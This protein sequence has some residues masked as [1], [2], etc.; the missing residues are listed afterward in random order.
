MA[1]EVLFLYRS[2]SLYV[3][4]L[5]VVAENPY[6]GGQV[7]GENSGRSDRRWLVLAVLCMT[8][9]LDALDLS[10]T[11][12]A[13]PSIGTDLGVSATALP[14]VANA[15]VLM[16]GGL[17]LLGGRLSDLLGRRRVFL[18]GLGLF[19]IMSLVCGLAG[20]PALLIGARA[21][22]G[23]GAALT[24]P[25]AVAILAGTFSQGPERNR[26]LGVFAAF[27]GTGFSVGLVAGGALTGALGW[28]WI[29]LVKVPVVA[30]VIALSLI[31][32]KPTPPSDR[33]R[34]FDVVGAVTSTAGL[35]LLALAITLLAAG[36][37]SL[38][39]AVLTAAVAAALLTG[40]WWVE[41]HARDPLLPLQLL[42]NRTVRVAD[43]VSLTVLAAPFGFAYL[44]STYL[45]DVA[46][47]SP[48][49]TGLAVLPG[50]VLSAIISSR[51]APLLV[52]RY[53]LRSCGSASLAVVAAGFA[54]LALVGEQP[55]Y[56]TAVLPACVICFGLGMGVAYP[57][58]TIAALTDVE[59]DEQGLAAGVQNAALQIGGG[60]GLAVVS[61]AVNVFAGSS[62]PT[63]HALVDAVQVGA[64]VG[65]ALPLIGSAASLA[66]LPSSRPTQPTT[67]DA[68]TSTRSA[69]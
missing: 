35:L 60:L 37:R 1:S 30:A 24:V 25:A 63:P 4:F 32:V 31:V 23:V 13:L 5:P 59:E 10:I 57:V 45:Q 29:F 11:Q 3:H 33:G 38:L 39:P 7:D 56:L 41:R 62:N 34:S 21:A 28:P 52:K 58:F 67:T 22:Q 2:V 69:P 46:G 53:G 44:A 50:S 6:G 61:S 36:S 48:L 14:W 49:R 55:S 54:M 12:V 9:L 65:A 64:L 66:F 26:A 8:I 47:Y 20:H 43:A 51:I 17:L 16:Y 27:A 18:L 19:G 40:F 68:T 42:S 15:Y